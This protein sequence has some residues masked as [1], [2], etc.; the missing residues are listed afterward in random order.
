MCTDF[1]YR[2]EVLWE[3][4]EISGSWSRSLPASSWDG[5]WRAL[6]EATSGKDEPYRS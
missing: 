3:L 5:E 1:V 4:Q 2:R 6:P